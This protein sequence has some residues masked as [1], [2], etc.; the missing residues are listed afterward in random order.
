LFFSKFEDKLAFHFITGLAQFPV[1]LVER[2]QYEDSGGIG[3]SSKGLRRKSRFV[4]KCG[5]GSR[6]PENSGDCSL[7]RRKKS[8][9]NIIEER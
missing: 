9:E 2:C 8:G 7:K 6:F 1:N 4:L 5:F 3:I